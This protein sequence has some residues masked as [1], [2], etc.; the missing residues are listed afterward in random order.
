MPG[1]MTLITN[2][3]WNGKSLRRILAPRAAREGRATGRRSGSRAGHP[4][5]NVPPEPARS[6]W[7]ETR[8]LPESPHADESDVR[9]R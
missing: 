5:V 7:S 1:D 2:I 6:R 3:K 4:G 8:T 9:E